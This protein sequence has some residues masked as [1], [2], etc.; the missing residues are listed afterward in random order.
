MISVV[1]QG[2]SAAR[3]R[4]GSWSR[5]D[6]SFRVSRPPNDLLPVAA[7]V[8]EAKAA[9][10]DFRTF[11]YLYKVWLTSHLILVKNMFYHLIYQHKKQL[12]TL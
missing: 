2:L 8:E 11:D 3:E 9:Q 1:F 4:K 10:L 6:R 7:N 12:S 5:H